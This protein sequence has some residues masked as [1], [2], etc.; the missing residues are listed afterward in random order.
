MEDEGKV[1]HELVKLEQMVPGKTYSYSYKGWPCYA[2]RYNTELQKAW[3]ADYANGATSG[4]QLYRESGKYSLVNSDVI[5]YAF[6][7][8]TQESKESRALFAP[9]MKKG[10]WDCVYA[11]DDAE[12][13]RIWSE[14]VSTCKSYGYDA[15]V[16]EKIQQVHDCFDACGVTY[17][18]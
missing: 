16:E 3:A 10:S 13:D 15:Y 2:E 11:A 17:T 8:M 7:E 9:V 12:F 14:M 6:P 1:N 18:K 4:I 5:A